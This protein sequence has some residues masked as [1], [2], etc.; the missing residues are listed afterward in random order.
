M[1]QGAFVAIIVAAITGLAGWAGARA[2]G[3]A[4]KET[5]RLESDGP[6]WQA[7]VSEMKAWTQARLEERDKQ[8]ASLREDLKVISEKLEVWKTRYFIAVQHIRDWRSKHPE[9]LA[10]LPLPD[11]LSRDF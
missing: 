7:Y 6:Q 11:D 5:A 1:E 2:T 9:S 4:Q 8:I 10:D 3:K